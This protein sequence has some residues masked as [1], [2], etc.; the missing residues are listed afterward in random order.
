MS[1]SGVWCLEIA[2]YEAGN[3]ETADNTLI[4]HRFASNA[5]L[6]HIKRD[7]RRRDKTIAGS[8]RSRCP[9]VSE[10]AGEWLEAQTECQADKNV[11]GMIL[12]DWSW[13]KRV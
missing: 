9:Q 11:H 8:G 12:D 10:D 6:L 13:R 3:R 4:V 1:E 7:G 5:Y 2:S